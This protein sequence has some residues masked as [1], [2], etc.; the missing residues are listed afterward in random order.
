MLLLERYFNYHL[1]H[2]CHS[3]P[4]P[5]LWT[6]VINSSSFSDFLPSFIADIPTFLI[7]V[8]WTSLVPPSHP[9]RISPEANMWAGADSRAGGYGA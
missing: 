1:I 3:M 7:S 4:I 5:S 8:V 9:V 6:H 2:S